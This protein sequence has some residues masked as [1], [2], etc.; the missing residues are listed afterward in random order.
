MERGRSS[1]VS[2][3]DPSN[4]TAMRD[5]Y[6]AAQRS[7]KPVMSS[8]LGTQTPC[9]HSCKVPVLATHN[10]ASTLSTERV[11]RLHY[12]T[13]S[14][15]KWGLSFSP[16]QTNIQLP[17]PRILNTGNLINLLVPLSA[18]NMPRI[19]P[20]QPVPS[21]PRASGTVLR[22]RPSSRISACSTPSFPSGG[23]TAYP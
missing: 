22:P 16:Y 6:L 13:F 15:I 19:S 17:N 20:S 23:E 3:Q 14:E 10:L 12:H 4:V 1:A 21:N 5:R 18:Y 8:F 11:T 9:R 7:W 2:Q